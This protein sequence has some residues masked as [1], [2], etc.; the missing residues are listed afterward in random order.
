MYV[1]KKNSVRLRYDGVEAWTILNTD[2]TVWVFESKLLRKILGPVGVGDNFHM[3]VMQRINIQRLRL[4]GH[5]IR[6]GEGA[7]AR[8]IF[9]EVSEENELVCVGR[10][11]SRHAKSN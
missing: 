5:F 2:V 8:R 3:N 1:V 11:R 9:V 4:L 7:P 6:M 10:I